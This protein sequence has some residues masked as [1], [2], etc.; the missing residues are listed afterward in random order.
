[1]LTQE[2]YDKI[3]DEIE[4]MVT[5]RHGEFWEE[6]LDPKTVGQ[7]A[8]AAGECDYI[9]DRSKNEIFKFLT[10]QTFRQYLDLRMMM[11]AY[12]TLM[13]QSAYS[14]TPLI[15]LTGLS[16]EAALYKK[17][18]STFNLSPREAFD[19]KRKELYTAPAHW[20]S[21]SPEGQH[22]FTQTVEIIREVPVEVVKL[23]RKPLKILAAA[24]LFLTV[25]GLISGH[26]I[27]LK[28]TW[29]GDYL[30][31]GLYTLDDNGLCTMK[32]EVELD[33]K[34]REAIPAE[35]H[36][37]PLQRDIRVN[38]VL[39]KMQ[40]DLA[41]LRKNAITLHF[42]DYEDRE[43]H[44]QL[45]EDGTILMEWPAVDAGGI[46]KM[47]L[48]RKEDYSQWKTQWDGIFTLHLSAGETVNGMH[49]MTTLEGSGCAVF[50]DKGA[51]VLL[52]DPYEPPITGHITDFNE[53]T[54]TV[55]LE[56]FQLAWTLSSRGEAGFVLPLDQ[57]PLD[58]TE[59][60]L[61]ENDYFQFTRI[62]DFAEEELIEYWFSEIF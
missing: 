46:Q 45:Q 19:Q 18:K 17:F 32:K 5:S 9:D 12:Q 62:G 52:P 24:A 15:N 33:E 20:N 1:M 6:P 35:L 48:I 23:D 10:G 58:L 54:M 11:Y 14:T 44:G 39:D 34:A 30:L 56:E 43:W 4:K 42:P 3:I 50:L 40:P 26:L 53:S 57:F 59:F 37:R 29:Q 61:S 13:K 25:I 38:Q 28:R 31:F 8:F 16:S 47:R 27:Q 21:L 60:D 2:R 36:I 22:M 41:S 51:F 49:S 55:Y 7:T